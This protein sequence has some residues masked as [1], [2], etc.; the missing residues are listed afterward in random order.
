MTKEVEEKEKKILDFVSTIK[1]Y[2]EN[3]AL[4]KQVLLDLNKNKN[5]K[6]T[7]QKLT[8]PKKPRIQKWITTQRV[9]SQCLLCKTELVRVDEIKVVSKNKPEPLPD[10]TETIP[11]CSDCFTFLPENSY[12]DR[13]FNLYKEVI[14]LGKR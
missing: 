14:W 9:K 3:L 10:I 8:I 4:L 7:A 2:P 12:V 1:K 6:T 13:L 5:K 11:Y